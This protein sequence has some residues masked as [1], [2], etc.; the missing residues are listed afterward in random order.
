MFLRLEEEG[1]GGNTVVPSRV[2]VEVDVERETGKD[3]FFFFFFFNLGCGRRKD[4]SVISE[5]F[6][7]V[8][9]A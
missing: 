2:H 1:E 5:Q 3:N 8:T 4:K 9:S 6:M 7:S